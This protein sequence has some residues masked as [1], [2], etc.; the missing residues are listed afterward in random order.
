[1]REIASRFRCSI[2]R[3]HRSL[4]HSG[5]PRRSVGIPR[6]DHTETRALYVNGHSMSEIASIIGCSTQCVHQHLTHMG[7]PKRPRGK[8]RTKLPEEMIL[9][10]YLNGSCSG[11]TLAEMF[12]TTSSTIYRLFKENEIITQHWQP[13]GSESPQWKGEEAGYC[14][15]HHRV[16]KL[17]GSPKSCSLCGT[18]DPALTYDWANISGRFQDPRDYIRLCRQCHTQ[19]DQEKK[20]SATTANISESRQPPKEIA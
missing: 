16:E 20:M 18:T 4:I 9:T 13:K 14:A 12:G 17:R 5:I 19:F 15:M 3:I 6:I 1:M 10:L 11:L 8:T 2:S 7:V